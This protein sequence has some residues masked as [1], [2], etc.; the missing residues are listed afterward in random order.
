MTKGKLMVFTIII[1][2][3]VWIA[4]IFLGVVLDKG[5]LSGWIRIGGIR[6]TSVNYWLYVCNLV[7][8][9]AMLIFYFIKRP[10]LEDPKEPVDQE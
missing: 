7:S 2:V 9:A 1:G 5:L 4:T 8:L 10:K 3:V 6:I